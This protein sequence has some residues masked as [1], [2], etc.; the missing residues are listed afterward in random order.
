MDYII[1]WRSNS[2]EPHID[3]DSHGFKETY[4]TFELAEQSAKETMEREGDQSPWYFG[5]E[6]FEKSNG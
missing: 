5:Y 2:R 6:I 3:V 4:S 1:I